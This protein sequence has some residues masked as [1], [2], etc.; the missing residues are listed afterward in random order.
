M[1]G[2][3]H[4]RGRTASRQPR[5]AGGVG[6]QRAGASQ[7]VA[8]LRRLRWSGS[9]G[10]NNRGECVSDAAALCAQVWKNS[11]KVDELVGAKKENLEALVAKYA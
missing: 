8:A 7:R 3:A 10:H 5:R 9:P 6:T 4:R 2:S 1:A 11:A